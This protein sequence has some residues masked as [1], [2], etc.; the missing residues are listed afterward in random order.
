MIVQAVEAARSGGPAPSELRLAWMCGDSLLPETGGVLDQDGPLM[1]KM[2][3]LSGIYRVTQKI[4][5]AH[6][7]EIHSLTDNE[8]RTWDYLIKAGIW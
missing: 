6:G 8:R 7:E 4:R 5:A 3:V 2:R 1:L